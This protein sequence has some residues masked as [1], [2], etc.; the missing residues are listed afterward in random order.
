MIWRMKPTMPLLKRQFISISSIL[1]STL[2]YILIALYND[3]LHAYEHKECH[4]KL[5]DRD[6]DICKQYPSSAAAYPRVSDSFGVLLV[7]LLLIA[8]NPFMGMPHLVWYL[9]HRSQINAMGK[10]FRGKWFIYLVV[11][12]CLWGNFLPI[13]LIYIILDGINVLKSFVQAII[14]IV[15][16]FCFK[17]CFPFTINLEDCSSAIGDRSNC[18]TN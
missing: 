16:H 15:L 12:S 2:L 3:A 7:L 14:L 8:F 4:S 13:M 1:I 5:E 9:Y 18:F 17:E 6:I 10:E 11:S